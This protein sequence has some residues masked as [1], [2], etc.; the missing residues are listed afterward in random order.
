MAQKE[1]LDGQAPASRWLMSRDMGISLKLP[2]GEYLVTLVTDSNEIVVIS[3]QAP[4]GSDY[5]AEAFAAPAEAPWLQKEVSDA[6]FE[7][8]TS[9]AAEGVQLQKDKVPV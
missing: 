5:S 8:D 3:I 1:D 7:I 6:S 9:L 2:E 4:K